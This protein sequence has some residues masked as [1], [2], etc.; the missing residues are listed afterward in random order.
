ME[1]L[2]RGSPPPDLQVLKAI[3]V[4]EEA[5]IWNF[6]RDYYLSDYIACG[7]SK[8]KFLTG[9]PGSGK[10]HTLLLMLE[11]ARR[12]GYITFFANTRRLR[13]NKFD[14][15]YQAVLDVVDV[16]N[17][18]TDYC[19]ALIGRL[20]YQAGQLAP[21]QDF[22]SWAQARG[23]AADSLRREIQEELDTL[24]QNRK[25][26]H[27]FALAFTQLCA[28]HLG[29]RR[30]ADGQKEILQEWLKSRSLPARVLK[31]LKIFTRIDK[32]N[33][34]HMMTSFLC[35]LRLCGHRG[36]FLAVDDLSALMERGPEGRALY[37]R[38]A[39]NEVY[40]SLRQLVDDFAGFEGAF[41]VFAGRTELIH[42]E[43]EGFKSYEAL[44]MRIQNEVS[45]ARLNR[46]ADLVNQDLIVKD[47]FT[48]DTCLELQQRMNAVLSL[49]SNLQQEDFHCLV[50][51][52]SMF[53]PVRR[54]VEAIISQSEAG[55]E[56]NG[57]VFSQ[58]GY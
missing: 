33:A 40:E 31:P 39:R 49:N 13:L 46:F 22:F 21:E 6:W 11:E 28:H 35:L 48:V 37:G 15:I 47:F 5:G 43:R 20:G 50:E 29:S 52:V 9:K 54:V 3:T 44:W 45:G 2:Q 18:V 7:G 8:V 23:R 56:R 4:G 27:N 32:Y 51:N 14:S 19:S 41:F 1:S 17:L 58:A 10:T 53:S 38:S 12:L 34:R 55:D 25:I 57:K 42:N 24:Y 16:E 36:L 30:L 26:N